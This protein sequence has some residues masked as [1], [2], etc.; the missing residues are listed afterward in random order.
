[1]VSAIH[2][3]ESATGIH[4]FPPSTSLPIPP[5]SLVTE[6]QL[7]VP[8]VI[9]Q[10]PTGY[11]LYIWQWICFSATLSN[12]PTFS[13]PALCPKVCSLCLY[14]HCCPLD[15]FISIIFIDS[16]YMHVY[17][18]MCVCVCVCVSIYMC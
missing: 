7:W 13:L 2:Q 15:R 6:H 14:L 3:H 10:I 18:Y 9:Q 16:I 12:H 17:I 8:C 11:L 1:M 5:L 4:M